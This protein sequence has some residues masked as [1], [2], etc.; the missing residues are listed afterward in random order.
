MIDWLLIGSFPAVFCATFIADVCWT[1]YFIEVGKHREIHAANWSAAIIAMGVFTVI[2]YNANHWLAI[3]SISGSWFGTWWTVRR[4]R[5]KALKATEAPEDHTELSP[6]NVPVLLNED[7]T[8]S[9]Y[10]AFTGG[11][12]DE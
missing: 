9:K 3:A 1:K 4:E 8:C 7:K 5:L 12:P 6:L 11:G 10:S 2:S